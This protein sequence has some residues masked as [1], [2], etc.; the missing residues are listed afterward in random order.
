MVIL[1]GNCEFSLSMVLVVVVVLLVVFVL[2]LVV[3]V[4]VRGIIIFVLRIVRTLLL[5]LVVLQRGKVSTVSNFL[6]LYDNSPSF[7]ARRRVVVFVLRHLPTLA[8][9]RAL[10]LVRHR[11]SS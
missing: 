3:V 11:R 1:D 8:D 4:V 7:L 10:Q 9:Q 6:G 5:V 2:V